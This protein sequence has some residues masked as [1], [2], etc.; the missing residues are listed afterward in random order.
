MQYYT[1]QPE[2]NINNQNN[3]DFK[4]KTEKTGISL[5]LL[6]VRCSPRSGRFAPVLGKT[7][8]DLAIPIIK[9]DDKLIYGAPMDVQKTVQFKI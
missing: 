3:L 4:R 6:R 2:T 1:K 8:Y 5:A 9:C 7:S